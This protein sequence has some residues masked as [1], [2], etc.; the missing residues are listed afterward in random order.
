VAPVSKSELH[1]GLLRDRV[2]RAVIDDIVADAKASKRWEEAGK[3]L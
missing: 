3:K 2:K 1:R